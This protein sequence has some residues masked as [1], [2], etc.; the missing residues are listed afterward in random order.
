MLTSTRRYGWR[1]PPTPHLGVILALSAANLD[2]LPAAV[3][4]REAMP[5]VYDQGPLG[6]CT[7]QSV[8]AGLEYLA[9]RVDLHDGTP[10]RLALYFD[11]RAAR[12]HVG[13]DDGAALADVVAA[14][15]VRGFASEDLWPYEVDRFAR[16]PSMAYR[17]R[18]QHTRLVNAEPLAHDL[19]TLLSTLAAGHPIAFGVEVFESFEHIGADGL[20]PLPESGE[21]ALGGHAMLAVGYDREAGYFLVRNSWGE[22]WGDEGYCWMPCD[23]LLDAALCGELFALRAVRRGP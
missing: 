21:L 5:R 1:R 9:R 3:D 12:G 13:E 6:S 17:E 19:G 18:A 23:Y 22:G 20:V 14:A 7:G 15:A 10:S 11:G 4:L 2:G 8:G 16:A